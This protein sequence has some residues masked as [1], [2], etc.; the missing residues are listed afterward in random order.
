M[1]KPE[2]ATVDGL[3]DLAYEWRF[4]MPG[5]HEAR[6]IEAALRAYA[7]RLAAAPAP[8]VLTDEQIDAMMPIQWGC[9]G[10]APCWNRAQVRAFARAL[11]A[12]PLPETQQGNLAADDGQTASRATVEA[13][14]G[15]QSPASLAQYVEGFLCR[16]W[17]ETDL[18][19]ARL[20]R[21]RQE[22][23][24]FVVEAQWGSDTGYRQLDAE[25]REQ[26][27]AQVKYIAHDM[28]DNGC[29]QIE[30]EIGGVSVERVTFAASPPASDA[31]SPIPPL[32]ST[33]ERTPS[34]SSEPDAQ[35]GAVWRKCQ[36]CG[37]NT[38][39]KA[40]AC[41]KKGRDEDVPPLPSSPLLNPKG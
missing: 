32:A 28:A 10:I 1:T 11:L 29:G 25:D 23:E 5:T 17:G 26:V 30:F 39:A 15:E 6:S 34:S 3:I 21:T 7:T 4:A 38:N 24:A 18:P 16:A 40:R 37:C 20:V 13:P 27:D 41:C 35:E 33:V 8:K 2:T 19:E 31:T 36:H 9:V 14:G 12:A 22:W